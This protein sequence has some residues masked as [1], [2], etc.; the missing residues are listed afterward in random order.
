MEAEDSSVVMVFRLSSGVNSFCSLLGFRFDLRPARLFKTV[1]RDAFQRN[2]DR[3]DNNRSSG[4]REREGRVGSG[5]QNFDTSPATQHLL[6]ENDKGWKE[7]LRSQAVASQ[8]LGRG[9]SEIGA[10]VASRTPVLVVRV[11]R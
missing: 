11:V 5:T 2:D 6:F 3:T 1:R 4:A 10:P 8:A 7:F 9:Q